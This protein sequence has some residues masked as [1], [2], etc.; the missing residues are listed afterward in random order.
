MLL[1]ANNVSSVILIVACW[2]LTHSF[3]QQRARFVASGFAA[4]GFTVLS[5]LLSRNIASIPDSS[6]AWQIVVTKII[7]AATLFALIVQQA[8]RELLVRH[9]MDQPP[10]ELCFRTMLS[11]ILEFRRRHPR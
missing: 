9:L 8:R 7:T 1:T 5:T 3:A 11:R 4:I 6:V 10:K 2:W